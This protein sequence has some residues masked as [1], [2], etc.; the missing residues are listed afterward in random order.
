MLRRQPPPR[1]DFRFGRQLVEG[2]FLGNPVF[3]YFLLFRD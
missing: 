3:G 2:F 1:L